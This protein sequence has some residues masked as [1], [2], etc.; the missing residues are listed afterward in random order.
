MSG[1]MV[2]TKALQ[3]QSPATP[4]IPGHLPYTELLLFGCSQKEPQFSS[5]PSALQT[6]QAQFNNLISPH[7][8]DTS[9]LGIQ[10]PGF[11]V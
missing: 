6:S 1:E 5:F 8:L 4:S 10:G 11:R 9:T 2:D 7:T 3:C